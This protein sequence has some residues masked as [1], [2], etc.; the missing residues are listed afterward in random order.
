MPSVKNRWE[1]RILDVRVEP[2]NEPDL[3]RARGAGV[4]GARA[5]QMGAAHHNGFDVGLPVLLQGRWRW[6]AG[7]PVACDHTQLPAGGQLELLQLRL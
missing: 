4:C 5:R 2:F 3:A 6:R 1:N 7:R